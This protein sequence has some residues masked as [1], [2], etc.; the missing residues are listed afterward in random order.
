MKFKTLINVF[1]N[2]KAF[3]NVV[4][5]TFISFFFSQNPGVCITK[6]FFF[7]PLFFSL[8][9]IFFPLPSSIPFLSIPYPSHH[10]NLIPYLESTWGLWD[11]KLP[12]QVKAKHFGAY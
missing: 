3:V 11:C 2:F 10:L 5:N 7:L 6:G 1:Y 4:Y 12:Q 8:P 9:S